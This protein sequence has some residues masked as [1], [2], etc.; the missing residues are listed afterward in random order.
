MYKGHLVPVIRI[1]LRFL[2][3]ETSNIILIQI[4]SRTQE[5]F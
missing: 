2:H 1:L 3:Y 5:G 4:E